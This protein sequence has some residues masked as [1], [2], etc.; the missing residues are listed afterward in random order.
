MNRPDTE[1]VKEARKMSLGKVYLVGAGPG[2]PGLMTLK[3]KALLECADVVIYD[4]LVSPQILAVINPQAE[5]IDAGKRKGRHSLIQDETTQLLIEKAG[6]NAIVVRLKGG[7]PFIFGRGGEE[8]EEL[9]KAGVAVEVVPGVTSGIAAPAYAGIPLTHR[10]YSSSVTFVTGHESAGKYRPEVNWQAIARGSETIVVY[11]GIHNL[12][13]IIGQLTA[14]ELSAETPV[15]LVRWGTRPEQEELI[16]TLS[17]IV[18][19]VEATGF[20]APAIAVIGNVVNL[21]SILSGCRP[22]SL[23]VK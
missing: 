9:V 4:A 20:A 19:Q 14:A 15:A 18:E 7:D 11:M 21:H 23:T 8:M 3:G 17:T 6:D 1:D 16:G 5:R 22:V 13:H 2:D 12:S 10:S